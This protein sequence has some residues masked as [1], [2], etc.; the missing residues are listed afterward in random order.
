MTDLRKEAQNK[1]FG[2]TRQIMRV[3]P[4]VNNCKSLSCDSAYSCI[5]YIAQRNGCAVRKLYP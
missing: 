4:R 2:I 5:I 3:Y 1:P